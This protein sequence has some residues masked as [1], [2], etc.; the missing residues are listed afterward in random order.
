MYLFVN[1]LLMPVLPVRYLIYTNR[2]K[3][4]KE[5]IFTTQVSKTWI[6]LFSFIHSKTVSV[7]T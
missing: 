2:I 1:I 7:S 5:T 6:V 3:A 4:K